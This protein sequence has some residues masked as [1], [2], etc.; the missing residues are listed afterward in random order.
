M[1]R[2]VFMLGMDKKGRG[3]VFPHTEACIVIASV[4]QGK[5]TRKRTYMKLLTTD[6]VDYTKRKSYIDWTWPKLVASEDQVI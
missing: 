6:I 2:W 3:S 4:A 1:F 5:M